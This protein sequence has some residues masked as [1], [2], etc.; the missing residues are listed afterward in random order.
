MHTSSRAL[1]WG[2]GSRSSS[3]MALQSDDR[4]QPP[5][6]HINS[7]GASETIS[8][9]LQTSDYTINLKIFFPLYTSI[10]L[11]SFKTHLSNKYFPLL[12]HYRSIKLRLFSNCLNKWLKWLMYEFKLNWI[13]FSCRTQCVLDFIFKNRRSSLI[14]HNSLLFSYFSFTR[15][16]CQLKHKLQNILQVLKIH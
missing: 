14:L 15:D 5:P 2:L 12:H 3:L 16:N 6:N 11:E 4:Y 13:T 1:V 9:F 7:I 10:L 8:E